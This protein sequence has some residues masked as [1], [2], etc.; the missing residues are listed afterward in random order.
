MRKYAI[1]L[2][3]SRADKDAEFNGEHVQETLERHKKILLEFAAKNGICGENIDIYEEVVSGD[4][5]SARPQVKKL[6]AAAE[7]R[8]YAGVFCMDIDRLARGD[9]VDQGIIER[10]FRLSGTKII[11]P[12][13]TYD[14]NSEFDEEYIEFELF[15]ARREFKVIGRRILRGRMQSAKEGRFIGSAAPFGYDKVKIKNDKG[16]TLVPN[17]EKSTVL[18]IFELFLNGAGK[19]AIADKLNELKI[20]PRRSEKWSAASVINILKNPVYTG[21]IRWGYRKCVKEL[22]KGT[23]KNRRKTDESCIYT[24][25]MHEAIISEIDF[26]KVQNELKRRTRPPIK[27]ERAL[28]NPLSGLI[29]CGICG[30]A[31]TRLGENKRCRFPTLKCSNRNCPCVS[32]KLYLVEN[33]VIESVNN[34]LSDSCFNVMESCDNNTPPDFLS[35]YRESDIT[36]K[37]R[38]LKAIISRITYTKTE[39]GT[40]R[41]TEK[42]NFVLTIEPFF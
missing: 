12:K 39:R 28:K 19:A 26:N 15:M 23:V 2:R 20:K 34:I 8:R 25:G 4:S 1:Y 31:M 3:K 10:T 13:K 37:N 14:P 9:T 11:T 16:Y 29:Y 17:A 21:K 41:N 7:T 27:T 24:N 22:S 36:Q 32:S 35:I 18:L 40:R 33:A 5:I 30:A 42:A 6:L 38:L